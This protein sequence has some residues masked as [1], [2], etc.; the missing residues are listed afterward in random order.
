[1]SATAKRGL[2]SRSTKDL[3]A[4]ISAFTSIFVA[5]ASL[6]VSC[7]SFQEQRRQFAEVQTEKLSITLVPR[8]YEPVRITRINFGKDGS[9]VITPWKLTVSNVGQ[10]RLSITSYEVSEGAKPSHRFY[11]GLSN[12]MFDAGGKVVELPITFE[13]GESKT[14]SLSVGMLVDNEVHK[15]LSAAADPNTGWVVKPG[16]ALAASNLDLLG[17]TISYEQFESGAKLEVLTE[18]RGQTFWYAAT[19]GRSN[20]FYGSGQ[21]VAPSPE[22]ERF[23][24]KPRH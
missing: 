2:D 24:F 19:T 21:S 18:K 10:Q 4:R 8:E 11:T 1:M 6:V 5:V 14:Y 22:L 3:V 7:A 13:P 16:L 23:G 15:A 12:G 17:N 9:V 20:V